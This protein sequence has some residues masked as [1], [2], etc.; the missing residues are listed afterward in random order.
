[1]DFWERETT[2]MKFKLHA[3]ETHMGMSSGEI[4]GLNH[5]YEGQVIL[6][7]SSAIKQTEIVSK[8]FT[9]TGVPAFAHMAT[10]FLCHQSFSSRHL[11]FL[12]C[13]YILAGR[14]EHI[15]VRERMDFMKMYKANSLLTFVDN[16][17]MEY[18]EMG[19]ILNSMVVGLLADNHCP[20][21][22]VKHFKMILFH[23]CRYEFYYP[24]VCNNCF[25]KTTEEKPSLRAMTNEKDG[26]K[27]VFGYE[28]VI[29]NTHARI[30]AY[31][32]ASG[33]GNGNRIY[34]WHQS[35]ALYHHNLQLHT[36][37]DIFA[38]QEVLHSAR[39]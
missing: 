5:P 12:H 23:L 3:A 21:D 16:T 19:A 38:E 32:N 6:D 15:S 4:C 36:Q 31:N 24:V 27:G 14:L 17:E 33:A 7:R 9:S 2:D 34:I 28:D 18:K 30:R 13:R 20:E 22:S 11:M 25:C 39:V 37:A 29:L 10:C 8:A 35:G 26:G 1:M